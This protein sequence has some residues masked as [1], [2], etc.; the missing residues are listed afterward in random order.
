MKHGE[1]LADADASFAFRTIIPC[2]LYGPHDKFD[3]DHAHLVP[4][5]IHKLHLARRDG[6][7]VCIWGDGEARRE[8]MYISDLVDF[9]SLVLD[10]VPALPRRINVGYGHDYTINEYYKTAAEALGYDGKMTH[11]L[12]KPVGM[13]RKLMNSSKA[14]KFGWEPRVRLERG[15]KLTWGYF[16]DELCS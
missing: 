16:R 12:E 2:N 8:F 9:I 14:R 1:Y 3:L 4:A 6:G 10:R 7:R 13:K 5:V 15:I 11:L